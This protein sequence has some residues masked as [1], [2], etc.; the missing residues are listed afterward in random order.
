MDARIKTSVRFKMVPENGFEV[1]GL[2]FPT[3]DNAKVQGKIVLV[4]VDINSPIDPKTGEILD[5][6][7][8]R[9]CAPTIKELA[10]KG[11][12]VVV[13]AHQGRPGGEDFT[14]LEKHS[15]KLSAAIGLDVKYVQDIFGPTAKSAIQKMQLGEV[16]LLE[17][18]RFCA[19]ETLKGPSEKMA[20]THLVQRLAELA[21]I[22]VNDAFGAAHRSQ[23][24]LVGFSAVLPTFAGRLMERELKG[25]GRALTPERPSVYVLGGAKV[26]DSLTIIENVF[27]K[28]IADFVLTGGLV[29]HA[30]LAASGK[31][32]GKPNLQLL[33]DKGFGEEIERAKRLLPQHGNKIKTPLDLIVDENGKPKELELDQLPTELPLGDI[34]SKT[35][36]EY[37][38]VILGAKTVVINGPLGIFEKQ[39]FEQGTF[40]VLE[41]MANSQAFTIL[42]GGHMVA[43][44]H[45][46]GVTDRIKHISTGGGACISFLSGETMPVVELLTKKTQ[47]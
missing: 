32:L 45:D 43:A 5:D 40:K 44:A 16:L 2:E 29:G 1:K 30:L 36:E 23:P 25:L 19:E 18:V 27:A 11:A 17:N 37:S 26:D 10:E 28:D 21:D 38:K 47:S 34:G 14:T 7:R 3:L 31:D 6:T 20:K 12:K 4:R 24:S 15:K 22:Y 46:A 8:I 39:G 13:L 41:A 33:L 9:R 35:V 42:G